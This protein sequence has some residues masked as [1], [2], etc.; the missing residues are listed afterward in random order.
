MDLDESSSRRLGRRQEA[1][2][3]GVVDRLAAGVGRERVHRRRHFAR[4]LAHS[5]DVRYGGK[6]GNQI[7]LIY[8]PLFTQKRTFA[9]T[10]N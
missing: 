6:S 4:K 10:A 9:E 3:A 5:V 2:V 1:G 7:F 8:G